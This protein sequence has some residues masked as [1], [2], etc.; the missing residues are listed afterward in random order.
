LVELLVV[1]AI[2]GI[3]IAL[4][5]PAVQS[6]REAGRRTQCKNNMKQVALACHTLHDVNNVLPPLTAPSAVALITRAAKPFNGAE[7]YTLFHWLLPYLEQTSV[8]GL[9]IRDPDPPGGVPPGYGGIQYFRVI[10]AYCCPGDPSG[11][12]TVG[13]SL[14]AHG[15]AWIWGAGNYGGNYYIFGNPEQNHMEGQTT[16]GKIFDGSAHTIF[17][18]EKY[19]TCGFGTNPNYGDSSN[20]TFY[21]SLWAD[22]NSIW[23]AVFCTNTTTKT[24][25]GAGYR[26]CQKFQVQP[27]WEFGGCDPGRAQAGHVAGMNAGMGDA[28]V[29][30]LNVSVADALWAAACDPRDSTPASIGQ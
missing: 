2:I 17:F 11:G 12:S 13:K 3:L 14:T 1:I 28:S 22:S 15:G 4:L 18:A 27:R 20:S 26:P 25:P 21:G 8:A 10:P 5:L 16:F 19:A 6:A 7:G 24:P 9:L 29:R 23:R 30:F